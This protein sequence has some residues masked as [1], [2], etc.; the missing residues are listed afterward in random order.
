MY[1]RVLTH[2]IVLFLLFGNLVWNRLPLTYTYSSYRY[3]IYSFEWSRFMPVCTTISLYLCNNRCNYYL[4]LVHLNISVF[5]VC[6]NYILV[7]MIHQNDKCN[8]NYSI[9]FVYF[10]QVS[11]AGRNFVDVIS[12]HISSHLSLPRDEYVS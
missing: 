5:S 12:F 6:K 10:C 2:I 11:D 4:Y 1:R 8:T 3:C 7:S 9:P